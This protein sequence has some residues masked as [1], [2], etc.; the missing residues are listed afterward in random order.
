MNLGSVIMS[1]KVDRVNQMLEVEKGK[2]MRIKL[3]KKMKKKVIEEEEQ[4]GCVMS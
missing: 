4:G 1:N 3:P 2:K